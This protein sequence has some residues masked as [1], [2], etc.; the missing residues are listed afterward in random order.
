LR[1][2]LRLITLKVVLMT[3]LLQQFKWGP[4]TVIPRVDSGFKLPELA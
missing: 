3:T 1:H 4:G 2:H